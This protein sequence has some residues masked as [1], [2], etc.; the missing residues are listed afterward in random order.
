MHATLK[1]LKTLVECIILLVGSID[2]LYHV[3]FHLIIIIVLTLVQRCE[4]K[5]SQY[6]VTKFRATSEITNETSIYRLLALMQLPGF[7]MTA[8]SLNSLHVMN[9]VVSKRIALSN[10]NIV[11]YGK[12][13]KTDF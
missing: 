12:Q 5:C 13:L 11:V 9:P 10:K 3:R 2:H 1:I 6:N 8:S 7:K 4:D